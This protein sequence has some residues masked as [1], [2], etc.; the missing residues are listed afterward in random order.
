MKKSLLAIVLILSTVQ[1]AFAAHLHP[2]KYYQEKWCYEH[3]G[4]AEVVLPD[5]TRADCVTSTHV[6]EFDF[7]KK[8][9]TSLC[10]RFITDDR[11]KKEVT[12][13]ENT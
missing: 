7:G 6:I 1:N 9:A 13:T 5:Q 8:W 3:N 12:R 4:Q 10:K 11:M 2:E